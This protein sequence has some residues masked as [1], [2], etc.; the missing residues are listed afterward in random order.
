MLSMEDNWAISTL[1]AQ[2]CHFI[3]NGEASRS[4]DE[5]FA[6]GAQVD[7]G[8]VPIVGRE[9]IRVFFSSWDGLKNVTAHFIGNVVIDGERPHASSRCYYQSWR[10]HPETEVF[11]PLR[12]ADM[13]GIGVYDDTLA[14]TDAGWR[15][16][17]RRLSLL[18][19]GPIGIGRPPKEFVAMFQR[20]IERT[21][22][23]A[24]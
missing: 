15:I 9:A 22:G 5:V 17:R 20:R 14:L 7:Y 12:E 1:L 19:P 6:A 23:S 10:W 21:G 16:T 2:Y 11:G 13:V 18:G 24:T 8:E 3:D 4:A